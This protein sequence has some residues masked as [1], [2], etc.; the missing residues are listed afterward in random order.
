MGLL[1]QF[2]RQ[3]QF[4]VFSRIFFLGCVAFLGFSIL[5]STVTTPSAWAEDYEKRDLM[6]TDFSG[7]VLTDSKFNFANLQGS[8]FSNSDLRGVSLFG[9]KMIRVNLEGANLSYATIDTARFNKANLTNAIL[10]GAFAY[11][12][13]FTGATIDG[14]DFTDVD[15]RGDMLKILCKQATGT[16]PVTGRKTRETLYCD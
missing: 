12:T 9:A 4:S 3:F 8:N 15:L 2:I 14:A 11:K 10:E 7:Q 16:N 5:I 1:N 13:D 6:N